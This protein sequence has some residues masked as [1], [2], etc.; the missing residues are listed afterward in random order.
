MSRDE[1]IR[2]AMLHARHG[3][4][5]GGKPGESAMAQAEANRNFS[6]GAAPSGSGGN[7]FRAS[8]VV[9]GAGADRLGAG[10]QISNTL[11]RTERTNILDNPEGA[12]AR[13]GPNAAMAMRDAGVSP[14]TAIRGA[15]SLNRSGA[16]SMTRSLSPVDTGPQIDPAGAV[17][18][19]DTDI[20][21]PDMGSMLGPMPT[22]T[23]YG[24][25]PL[26]NALSMSNSLA[27][28]N[29]VMQYGSPVASGVVQDLPG[30]MR[31]PFRLHSGV[32]FA[33][34]T[35]TAV[36]PSMPG[37]VVQVSS[38]TGYG[39]LVDVQDIYGNIQRYAV[40]DTGTIGVQPGQYVAPGDVIG[41]V[42]AQNVPK[43][44][45]HLHFEH[46]TP[47][48]RAYNEIM[49]KY[50]AGNFG[51]FAG[52]TK[53]PRAGGTI[54]SSTGDWLKALGV[55]TGDVMSAR[56]GTPSQLAANA[57]TGPTIMD[58]LAGGVQ[59]V[60]PAAAPAP[61]P[62]QV[63]AARMGTPSVYEAA[64]NPIA[65]AYSAQAQADAI[66]AAKAAGIKSY[67]YNLPGFENQATVTTAS[68]QLNALGQQ[69]AGIQ[70]TLEAYNKLTPAQ[71]TAWRNAN[72]GV[73][74]KLAADLSALKEKYKGTFSI[75]KPLPEGYK[76]VGSGAYTVPAPGM[77]SGY[78]DYK[79]V[80]FGIPKNIKTTETTTATAP[81]ARAI[82]PG[83]G[84]DLAPVVAS[85][86]PQSITPPGLDAVQKAVPSPSYVAQG[87]YAPAYYSSPAAPVQVAGS[88]SY[89]PQGNY[90]PEY[91]S[92]PLAPTQVAEA[93]IT[94]EVPLPRP[95]PATTDPIAQALKI[96]SAATSPETVGGR[97]NDDNRE[98]NL[99]RKP[100]VSEA[101][102]KALLA[103]GYTKEQ[104]KKMTPEEIK[105]ILTPENV[106]GVAPPVTP[107]EPTTPPVTPTE[108]V[109]TP[110]EPVVTPT[111][112]VVAA[113]RGG[114]MGYKKGGSSKNAPVD[115]SY[116]G[117]A[118]LPDL[119]AYVPYGAP[120]TYNFPAP[121]PM[122]SG[123]VNSMPQQSS[124]PMMTPAINPMMQPRPQYSQQE[125]YFNPFETLFGYNQSLANMGRQMNSGGSVNTSNDSISNAMRLI[126][127]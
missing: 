106:A 17:L 87:N 117:P 57:Y 97:Q 115:D 50:E 105:K 42:G 11:S 19:Y 124:M 1:L 20:R 37:T 7:D 18:G 2:R 6:A 55:G 39:P 73:I 44:F 25:Q 32:D 99:K 104:I 31:G 38:G 111:E 66:A 76:V 69:I 79:N 45:E 118:K 67:G 119:P 56:V 43:A 103:K 62:A 8:P 40:H 14:D 13:L 60:A 112:P 53:S 64:A 22:M 85:A 68:T 49:G 71:Q 21:M 51:G 36:T 100:P 75:N 84:A 63:A 12:A 88:P 80:T 3:Y 74:D 77:I 107:T 78:T 29:D 59:N 110:T 9:G 72:P 70:K 5:V 86:G 113:A 41:T 96:A 65:N 35:G 108:P 90:A 127:R 48:D 24:S 94:G 123:F 16:P 114:R 47:G 26:D 15:M 102:M 109:V 98:R 33:A 30:A 61:A 52:S 120:P 125:Q 27:G 89:A 126:R 82:A 95:R 23:S 101:D 34:P 10:S 91:Y 28:A 4:A 121:S 83:Y 58:R 54:N 81:M 116:Y 93:P 122:I 46:L 92:S